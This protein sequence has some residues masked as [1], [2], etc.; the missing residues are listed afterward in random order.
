MVTRNQDV[1]LPV[2][3]TPDA[4]DDTIESS[5]VHR[6]AE[7]FSTHGVEA[8]WEVLHG[9][10]PDACLERFADEVPDA[11]FVMTSTRRVG[12]EVSMALIL[13]AVP[14]RGLRSA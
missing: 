8:T 3:T 11:V 6:L 10:A 13:T 9:D 5:H 4:P 2:A 1:V 7:A 12:T 14:V